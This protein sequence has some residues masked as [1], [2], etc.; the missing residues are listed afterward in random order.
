[1]QLPGYQEGYNAAVDIWSLGVVLFV[2]LGGQPPFA[3]DRVNSNEDSSSAMAKRILAGRYS[4]TGPFWPMIGPELRGLVD[5]M[6][7]VHPSKRITL[8]DLLA[9]PAMQVSIGPLV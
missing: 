8:P 1:M 4:Y 3:D 2:C 7:I 6:L 9:S 5:M